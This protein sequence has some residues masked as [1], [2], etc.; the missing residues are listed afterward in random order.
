MPD[1]QAPRLS[2]ALADSE[3]RVFWLDS[4]AAPAPLPPVH[5]EA[6]C[7]LAIVGGGFTGLWAALHAASEHDVILLEGDRCGWGASA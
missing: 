1:K 6:R 2:R 4:P 3:Q 7:D 5:G